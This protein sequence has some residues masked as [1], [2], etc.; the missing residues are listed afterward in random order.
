MG[1]PVDES[2]WRIVCTATLS[3]QSSLRSNPVELENTHNT[4]LGRQGIPLSTALRVLRCM[5]RELR[6]YS[7]SYWDSLSAQT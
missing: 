5:L 7:E 3:R 1:L 4:G 6:V 2:E